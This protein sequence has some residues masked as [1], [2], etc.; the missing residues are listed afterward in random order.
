MRSYGKAYS[1]LVVQLMASFCK[2]LYIQNP[3]VNRSSIKSRVSEDN[4]DIIPRQFFAFKSRKFMVW[5]KNNLITYISFA[6]VKNRWPVWYLSYFV[7][8]AVS[9]SFLLAV[10]TPKR[11]AQTLGGLSNLLIYISIIYRDFIFS[12]FKCIRSCIFYSVS[13]RIDNTDA[14]F[15]SVDIRSHS[16]ELSCT[17][18]TVWR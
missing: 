16:V 11:V 15:Y 12:L 9:R 13:V 7:H 2:I 5:F 14:L 3:S 8:I 1:S 17:C 6:K 10:L 18:K 4:I